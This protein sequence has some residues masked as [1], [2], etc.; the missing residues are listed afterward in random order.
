MASLFEVCSW[1]ARQGSANPATSGAAADATEDAS[2][3]SAADDRSAAE[4][5]QVQLKE[6]ASQIMDLQDEL[7]ARDAHADEAEAQHS[8]AVK[9][10]VE[11]ESART[12]TAEHR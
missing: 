12:R 1:D 10:A 11:E 9:S 6:A 4:Q 8:A 7:A 5:S 3:L 2:D